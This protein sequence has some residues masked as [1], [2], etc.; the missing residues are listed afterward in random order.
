M[1]K[2]NLPSL[3]I[4][5]LSSIVALSSLTSIDTSAQQIYQW[6]DEKGRIHFGERP[7]RD[8]SSEKVDIK[9]PKYLDGRRGSSST[10]Q[11]QSPE[12]SSQKDKDEVASQP[13]VNKERMKKREADYKR[14]CDNAKQLLAQMRSPSNTRFTMPDGSVST[15]PPEERQKQIA[16]AKASMEFYCK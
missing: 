13:P 2:H 7:P 8:K 10:E 16:A 5:A 15:M 3:S 12:D 9:A 4:I 14:N 11:N 1:Q 6:K